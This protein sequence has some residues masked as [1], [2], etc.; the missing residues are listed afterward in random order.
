MKKTAASI[1]VIMELDSIQAWYFFYV[2]SIIFIA[3]G[4]F[5]PSLI[6]NESVYLIPAK[7]WLSPEF[8]VADWTVGGTATIGLSYL[9]SMFL[10]AFWSLSSDPIFVALSSRLVLWCGVVFSIFHFSRTNKIPPFF[11]FVGI[12][13]LT[14]CFQSLMAHE[15]IIGGSE[16]KN[17]AYMCA[18]LSLS[19]SLKKRFLLAGIF[20][21][22]ALNGHILVGGY[23]TLAHTFLVLALYN[24]N[25]RPL[26]M[27]VQY[28]APVAIFSLP[29]LF[30]A[31]NFLGTGQADYTPVNAVD[32]N[33][34]LVLF[35]GPHHLDPFSF[36]YPLKMV[37]TVFVVVTLTFVLVKDQQ[38]TNA[39]SILVYLLPLFV[40]CIAGVFARMGEFYV[41]L[42]FY[43]FRV[44]DS[45]VPLF[46]FLF[47]PYFLY[48]F[49]N[50]F[51]SR[52]QKIALYF[53]CFVMFGLVP[54]IVVTN[55]SN[56]GRMNYQAWQGQDTQQDVQTDELSREEFVRWVEEHSANNDIF[57]A[58][59]FWFDFW[60]EVGRPMV[61]N[62]KSCP[63][64]RFHGWYDRIVAVNKG[65]H[66]TSRGFNIEDEIV[67][68]F[69][70]LTATDLVRIR[71][72]YSA[73]YYVVEL[74]RAELGDA[75]VFSNDDY[76]VYDL[77]VLGG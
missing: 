62:F 46:F 8:L 49:A 11:V 73:S 58:S 75:L 23:T 36:F 61:I 18:I 22:I 4:H 56:Q 68:N 14:Y 74:E 47:V 7:R 39:K 48:R 65:H 30:V 57:L 2:L 3:V 40:L 24:Q 38:N 45:M 31:L 52:Y 67:A 5:T 77:I 41:L 12:V 6:G 59:P 16:Q 21:G 29:I 1:R 37:G 25:G 69:Q 15:W 55:F 32:P 60:L 33:E 44:G 9:Y 51:V 76:Y 19:F 70:T 71:N 54:L 42:K 26:K 20:S 13:Q 10:A 27:L 72:E 64:N 34:F 66:F 50:N 35:R 63:V 17:I 53:W 43:P 28:G